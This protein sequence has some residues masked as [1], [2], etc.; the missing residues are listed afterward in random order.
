M[1]RRHHARVTGAPLL[2]RTLLLLMIVAAA[3]AGTAA[4]TA[5]AAQPCWKRL[6]N[7]WYD[8]RIDNAYTVNCYREAIDNLP[9]DVRSY[10]S[11]R[12]D[13]RR[14]LMSAIRDNG[15]LG[16]SG[17]VPP[18]PNTP[19]H[20]DGGRQ[21]SPTLDDDESDDILP[22]ASGGP[23]DDFFDRI[24]PSSATA[25]PLPILI[26]AGIAFLLLAAA[27]ASAVTRRVQARRVTVA[28]GPRERR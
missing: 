15:D 19:P 11:A 27:L 25:I 9:E 26:L 28:E 24:G 4:G 1:I 13:I 12:E 7:D 10:S 14:A 8:G 18:E 20:R 16:S 3:V 23:F 22:Q 17:M 6:L 2:R 5:E 21:E